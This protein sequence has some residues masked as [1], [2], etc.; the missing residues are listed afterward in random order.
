M[1]ATAPS[2]MAIGVAEVVV[3]PIAGFIGATADSLLGATLQELRW[4]DACG[5]A[6]ETDPHACGTPARLVRGVRGFSN[7]VVN[8]LATAVGAAAAVALAAAGA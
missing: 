7:D 8:L 1:P 3:V 6:C 5:R 4:C 2:V